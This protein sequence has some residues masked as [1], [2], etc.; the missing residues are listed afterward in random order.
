MIS[1]NILS[2]LFVNVEA[3]FSECARCFGFLATVG[4]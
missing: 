2:T 4:K 3:V 1:E